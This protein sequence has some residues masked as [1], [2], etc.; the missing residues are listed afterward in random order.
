MQRGNG[1][2][3]PEHGQDA[4]AALITCRVNVCSS[5]ESLGAGRQ[6]LPIFRDPS[7]TPTPTP[8]EIAGGASAFST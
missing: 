1:F 2:Q 5:A 8:A 3:S 7:I 6:G 4:H